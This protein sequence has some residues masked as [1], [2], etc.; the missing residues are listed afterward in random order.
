M[1]TQSIVLDWSWIIDDVEKGYKSTRTKRNQ[2]WEKSFSQNSF[3]QNNQ[4]ERVRDEEK[5]SWIHDAKDEGKLTLRHFT[6]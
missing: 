2:L 1:K 6:D 3:S 4:S 5:N